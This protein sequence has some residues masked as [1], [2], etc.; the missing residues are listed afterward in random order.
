MPRVV[1][2]GNAI[3]VGEPFLASR[4]DQNRPERF[5]ACVE[6]LAG[7]LNATTQ[8]ITIAVAEHR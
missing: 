7:E 2:S 4:V 3:A 5:V 6:R 8:E 1:T